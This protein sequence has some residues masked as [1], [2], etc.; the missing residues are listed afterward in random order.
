MEARIQA[1]VNTKVMLENIAAIRR[2]TKTRFCAVVKADAYGHGI[3]VA[4]TFEC[5]VDCFA[6]AT[7]CEAEELYATGVKKDILL[8]GSEWTD[9][10]R[11]IPTV[12]D[13]AS[14]KRCVERRGRFSVKIDTGMNR[15]G[16]N[17][18]ETKKVF[19]LFA[20]NNIMPYSCFSHYYNAPQSCKEQF[21]T[22]Q[23]VLSP[24]CGTY[25]R[26]IAA[27]S[28]IGHGNYLDMVR[29]GLG[30]YGYGADFLSPSLK[31]RAP[32]VS[33][34]ELKRGDNI[35]YGYTAEHDCK[36]AV[37]GAG[38]A[39]G[40]RHCNHIRYVT[41]NGVRCKVL[42]QP[43]M[44]MTVIDISAVNNVATGDYA[45]IIDSKRD[46]E[47]LAKAHGTIVYEVLTNVGKRAVRIYE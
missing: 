4:K 26:H 30:V 15:L 13:Y 39:D 2:L 22:F 34:H 31:L 18:S 33:L 35:G 45:Y 46:A 36:A 24:Y 44:D 1:I 16:L 6:V 42:G 29:C 9:D 25:L 20:Q 43:C 7:V 3:A 28:A 8:L 38:Y 19:D 23:R 10:S 47:R 11:F 32:I 37:I 14:A 12:I 21:D 17:E 27:T 5:A 40:M 41:V